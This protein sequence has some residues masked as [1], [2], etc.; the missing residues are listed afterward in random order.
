[1]RFERMRCSLVVSQ[2]SKPRATRWGSPAMKPNTKEGFPP[3]NAGL[4]AASA[5]DAQIDAR[6]FRFPDVSATH[7]AFVYAGDVWVAPK[8]GGTAHRLSSPRGQESFPRFSPDGSQIAFSAN[9]DGNTDALFILMAEILH[10]SHLSGRL[11]NGLAPWVVGFRGG[12][13]HANVIGC[14][15]FAA[16]SGSSAATV[17]TIGRVNLD[18]LFSRGYDRRL[19]I[20]SLAGNV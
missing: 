16:V 5:A 9:Y 6:M 13:L 11:F 15:L 19:A 14:T 12:L 2:P 7:I 10:R 20:G 4:L 18:E 1:M 3:L 17:L 8:T